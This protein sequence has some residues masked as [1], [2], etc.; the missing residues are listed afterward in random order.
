MRYGLSIGDMHNSNRVVSNDSR[1]LIFFYFIFI[2]LGARRDVVC[3]PVLRLLWFG[4][5]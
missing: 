3:V 2:S 4:E 5:W 1:V